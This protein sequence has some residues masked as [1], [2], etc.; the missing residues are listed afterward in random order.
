MSV[1]ATCRSIIFE[2]D[3]T[4]G[5][6]FDLVL[7]ALIL[8]S[9]SCVM[10]ESVPTY[11]DVWGDWLHRVE[12]FCL[13][14]FLFEYIL[15][16]WC[17]EK[18]WKYASSFYGIID[19]LSITPLFFIWIIFIP[20]AQS[21]IVFRLFRILRIFRIFHLVRYVVEENMLLH[22]FRAS[23]K[24]ISIFLIT[25]LP[26]VVLFGSLMYVVEGGVT[27]GFDTIPESIYWA[28]V[29]ITTVGYGDIVPQT[30][31]GRILASFSMIMGYAL[32]AIPTSILTLELSEAKYFRRTANTKTCPSC[33]VEGHAAHANFCRQ[34]GFKF[35]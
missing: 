9:V 12:V 32:V 31:I 4:F 10:L 21:F 16:L 24:K 25:I 6:I 35:E 14:V 5:R 17:V 19:L 30:I 33:A 11:Y 22:A 8:I 29:T 27:P 3:T 18:P 34:C 28:I 2:A 7:I 26:I 1:K 15:R 20:A 13:F 23:G